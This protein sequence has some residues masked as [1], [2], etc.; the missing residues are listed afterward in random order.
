M[1]LGYEVIN[2]FL[3]VVQERLQVFLVDVTCTLST[4]QD[5]I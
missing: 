1:A 3:V 5:K 2:L 4:R